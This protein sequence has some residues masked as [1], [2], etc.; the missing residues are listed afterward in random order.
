MRH[1]FVRRH[2]NVVCFV[3]AHD[4]PRFWLRWLIAVCFNGG[5]RYCVWASIDV[6]HVMKS[7]V[8]ACRTHARTDVLL[9]FVHAL[10][11][12]LTRSEGV[13]IRIGTRTRT[14]KHARRR[15]TYTDR[16]KHSADADAGTEPEI[17]IDT[18]TQDSQGIQDKQDT[19]IQTQTHTQTQTPTH[20]NTHTQ[21]H[22]CTQ[23]LNTFIASS[24]THLVTWSIP[25]FWPSC[26]FQHAHACPRH[27]EGNTPLSCPRSR[28][29]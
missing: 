2:F 4:Y 9:M 14:R 26:R 19:A 18:D 20:T 13:Q 29:A 21:S 12:V 28:A 25:E 11:L 5:V 22:T 10:E 15:N 3:A 16:R 7:A 1:I 17:D 24:C 27:S 8:Q 23:T 6:A